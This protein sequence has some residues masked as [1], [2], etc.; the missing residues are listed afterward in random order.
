VGWPDVLEGIVVLKM[1]RHHLRRHRV[2]LDMLSIID[3]V[4][5]IVIVIATF[6]LE[7]G[8]TFMLVWWTI[9]G[10]ISNWHFRQ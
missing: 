2:L 9:L 6:V 10:E 4:V 8:R 3:F 7:V 1:W 5:L